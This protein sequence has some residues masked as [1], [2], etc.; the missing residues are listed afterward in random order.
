MPPKIRQEMLST[1]AQLKEIAGQQEAGLPIDPGEAWSDAALERLRRLAREVE[2][3]Q[4]KGHLLIN[5]SPLTQEDI[6]ERGEEEC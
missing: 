3:I 4:H 1:I 6:V 5:V 2:Q